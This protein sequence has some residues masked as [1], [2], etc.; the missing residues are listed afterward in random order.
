M[1]KLTSVALLLA[2]TAAHAV[3]PI[4][5][6]QAGEINALKARVTV[7]E[8]ALNEAVTT[9]QFVGISSTPLDGDKGMR[10]L[11]EA[12]AAEFPGSRMC[13]SEEIVNTVEYPAGDL[14]A[15]GFVHPTFVADGAGLRDI[16]GRYPGSC[17]GWSGNGTG[18]VV[19]VNGSFL[20]ESCLYQYPVACCSA[21]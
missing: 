3:D 15:Y 8:A 6:Y 1:I 14:S 5:I 9:V 19:N 17:D 18:L 4:D 16:S 21:Q 11:H 13:F 20:N 2:S 10:P 7:L 12:C